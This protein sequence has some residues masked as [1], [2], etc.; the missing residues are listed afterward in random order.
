M[1]FSPRK[2]CFINSTYKLD[3]DAHRM[4]PEEEQELLDMALKNL[5][6]F[7]EEETSLDLWEEGEWTAIPSEDSPQDL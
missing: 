6:S 5:T 7:M 1:H 4:T 3:D 2:F